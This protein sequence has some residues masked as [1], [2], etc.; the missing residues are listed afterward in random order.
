MIGEVISAAASELR[1]AFRPL[2]STDLFYQLAAFALL[3]PLVSFGIRSL[4]SL[5][6]SAVL[7][8][9][10]ILRFALRPI[11]IV[12][13]VAAAAGRI[14]VL[15]LGQ[16]CLMGIAFDA[17]RGTRAPA[18]SALSWGAARV[19]GILAVTTRLVVRVLVLCA[20]FLALAG[21]VYFL[22]LTDF[23]INYYL[24]ERPPAFWV[25]AA[26]I[27]ALLLVMAALL[28]RSASSWVYALPLLLFE[29]VEPSRA[30]RE[31][32]RRTS[33]HRSGIALVLLAWVLSVTLASAFGL[34]GA[35]AL[36][37]AILPRFRES[38]SLLVPALGIA[39]VLGTIVG[40]LATALASSL[41]ATLVVA[42]YEKLGGG[43]RRALESA[44]DDGDRRYLLQGLQG[45]RLLLGVLAAAAVSVAIGFLLLGRLSERRPVSVIGHRGA[46]ALAPENSLSAVER[47]IEAGADWVEID[48]QETADG[49]VVV[50]HDSDFMKV[51]GSSLKIWEARFDEVRTL[52]IGSTFGPEFIGEPVPTLEEVLLRAKGRA[53]VVIELK[54]Y[55]HDQR[56]EE[57]VADIVD[58]H[59]MADE[60]SVMSLER[61]G[62]EKMAAL[63]PAYRTGLLAATAVGRLT[64]VDV[65]FLAVSVPLATP[66]F[67]RRAHARGQ[68][69]YV[70][71]VNDELTMAQAIL[72]GVDGL[73]TDRPAMARAVIERESELTSVERL[74]LGAAFWLG[75]EPEEFR[76]SR[77]SQ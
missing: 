12:T 28:L 77:D 69:V 34:S 76:V 61:A 13:L 18:L 36:A 32:E 53:K 67:A 66:S 22:L 44:R 15:A 26:V 64:E 6:G 7:A 30:L 75:V 58:R 55:G 39:V 9:Q 73:I 8:D 17:V 62:I 35:R 5:S 1:R 40:A 38:L 11:G 71:T 45:R 10:E 56:L 42:L 51:A 68:D 57:R 2:I 41:F 59:E 4:V 48:V 49:E 74:L 20:P 54:Y 21:L 16:A 24:R 25:A 72:R 23:D 65:D 19:A 37:V 3:T 60:I 43:S 63:R 14:A 31:S 47:A 70:W 52:D 33:G 29:N 50:L 46:A 27:G